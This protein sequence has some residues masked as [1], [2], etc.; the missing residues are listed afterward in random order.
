MPLTSDE[1]LC[2][3]CSDLFG[4]G[5]YNSKTRSYTHHANAEA[6]KQALELACAI[7]TRLCMY[8]QINSDDRTWLASAG[9]APVT[10]RIAHQAKEKGQAIL[11]TAGSRYA[12]YIKLEPRHGKICTPPYSLEYS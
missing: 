5:R 10:Y 11:F 12:T 4:E 6:I 9:V 3:A 8:F 7:C 1:I 2:E